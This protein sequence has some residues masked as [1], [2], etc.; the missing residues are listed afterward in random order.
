[1]ALQ[2]KKRMLAAA[3]LS[4]DKLKNARLG[5]DDLMELFRHGGREDSAEGFLV[6]RTDDTGDNHPEARH[7]VGERLDR[8]RQW[9]VGEDDDR[10]RVGVAGVV[11]CAVAGF[12]ETIFEGETWFGD[13]DGG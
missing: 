3:A 11:E 13:D 5:L 2:E 4:G 8:Q 6:P 1:M 12:F 10:L 9:T 7:P